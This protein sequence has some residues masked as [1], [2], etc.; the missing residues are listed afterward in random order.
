[1]RQRELIV[2]NG[3]VVTCDRSGSTAEAVGIREGRIAAVGDARTVR[4]ALG[5]DVSEIDAGGRT[6]LP[7]LI[8]AHN[9]L[10]STSES[11]AAVNARFPDV[12]SIAELQAAVDAV[13][14][15][16]PPGQWVRGF[17]MDY[18]KYPDGRLPT[19][20]DLD[21]VTTEH[22]V[23]ILHVSGHYALANSRAFAEQG[24][25]DN[26]PDPPGGSFIR[27]AAGRPTGLLLDTATNLI[28]QVSV[29]I[30]CHGPNFHF[31]T[32]LDD[33]LDQLQVGV[34]RYLE[35]GLTT[36]CDPQV[37][38]RELVAYREA[39]RRGILGLRTVCMP[40]SHQLDEL[41]AIGL[42]GPFG[43]DWLRIGAMKFYADGSLIGG[44]AAFTEPY[45]QHG[46]YHGTLYHP[47]GDLAEF[48]RRAHLAGWQVG[49][50]TQGDRAI[51]LSLDAI[52]GALRAGGRESQDMRHR[53]EHCG[54]P[55]PEQ[56]RQIANLG[57]IPVRQPGI[58]HDIGD[59]FLRMLPDRAPALNPLR[60][61]LDLGIR[62]V[63]SSDAFV[64]SYRPLDTIAY[65]VQRRTRSG[66]EIGPEHAL[67]ID[68]AVRAHTIDAA[69]ALRLEDRL[70]SIERGKLADLTILDGDLH[71]TPAS[72]IAGIGVWMTV[73]DGSIAYAKDGSRTSAP[74]IA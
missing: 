70:G 9:H 41:S 17:G 40:L 61:E 44:T 8:D 50:H 49:I 25:D 7:G 45:G 58:M 60:S 12:G 63:I 46:E 10:L 14:E 55:T 37:T 73:L 13:A 59:D 5:R 68:E 34:A 67:T 57:V 48:V 28:L 2:T 56:Q 27:D 15:R 35:A 39:R 72:D 32:P 54:Y 23:I 22:P 52:E 33:L 30:G 18:A 16:T 65:A 3:R 71:A 69:V 24:L 42:A 29:D 19:R 21:A 74:S 31:D 62:P 51:Q 43:D 6:I 26:V 1:M 64:H 4:E 20:D 53:I 66:A 11:F 47:P 38:R 36:V